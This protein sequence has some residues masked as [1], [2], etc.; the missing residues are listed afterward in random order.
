[1]STFKQTFGKGG[2]GGL[3]LWKGEGGGLENF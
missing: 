3:K 1:M 2:G